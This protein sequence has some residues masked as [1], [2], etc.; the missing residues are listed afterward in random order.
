MGTP[1]ISVI[2]LVRGA[3][4]FLKETAASLLEQ[5]DDR[6][7][8]IFACCGTEAA[9]FENLRRELGT[10]SGFCFLDLGPVTAGEARN[11]ALSAARGDYVFFTECGDLF[12]PGMLEQLYRKAREQQADIVACNYIRFTAG[13]REFPQTGI[14]TEWIPAGASVF[15]HR[16]CPDYVL[17]IAGP[18]VWNKLYRREFLRGGN[19]RFDSLD[20]FDDLSFVAVAMARAERIA[21]VTD[22][23]V[24]SRILPPSGDLNP[25]DLKAAVD[26]ALVQMN[27]LPQKDALTSAAARFVVDA[28]I[29]A[30][31]K[32]V[33]DFGAPSAQRLYRLAHEAFTADPLASLERQQ[34]RN[35]ELYREFQ[36]V[37]KH[38]YE[39]M[40]QL[41]AKRL[42]VS[43][44][45]Y[46]RRIG[47]VGKVL[48]TIYQQTKKPDKVILW[49]AEEQFPGKEGDLPEDLIRLIRENRLTVRWC[50]DLRSHKKYFHAFQEYPQDLVVTVDDDLEYSPKM[51][52]QLYASYLLYPE[53]VSAVRT[54][55][56]VMSEEKS[57]LPYARWGH[58][59]D[60][61]LNV[62]SMQLLATSGAGT[63]HPPGLF[64]REFFDWDVIRDTCL[65][66]DDLWLKAMELLS[67][68]PVVQAAPNEPLRVL[69]GTQE[70][71][72]F[73][74]NYRQGQNDVQLQNIIR[75]TD[76][77]FGPGSFLEKLTNPVCGEAFLNIEAAA[78]CMEQAR[79]AA[80]NRLTSAQ[81][82]LGQANAQKD[83]LDRQLREAQTR[84]AEQLARLEEALNRSREE[85]RRISEE[86]QKTKNLLK[87][88][89]QRL[90]LAR[91]LKD[92]EEALLQKKEGGSLRWRIKYGIYR[93]AWIP[94]KILGRMMTY[95]KK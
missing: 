20:S 22:V 75:W 86:M 60:A 39:A 17:R 34:L 29:T 49:L 44:T 3:V 95:L 92:L 72:L 33:S 93:L 88:T 89:R 91:Q 40:K 58:E 27:D 71:S 35:G 48:Q 51:L 64:R 23:L 78:W 80:R 82:K 50:R 46:P 74:I 10:D 81:E 8:V 62:P 77:R 87:E 55:L 83:Q 30:L 7:E 13:G 76:A 41:R 25:D 69:P 73:D 2:V 70:E 9:L 16:D 11:R 15:S 67:D 85:T 47:T 28:Y 36:T 94:A 18:M 21:V 19:L 6:F 90:S 59:L 66:A 61:L 45:T 63:L 52:A 37:Q 43:L 84:Q 32:Y 56:M 54:H 79:R 53:A 5:T 57:L 4:P 1:D 38:S 26:S 31:K 65:H 24:R 12:R 42:I 68:V 14:R